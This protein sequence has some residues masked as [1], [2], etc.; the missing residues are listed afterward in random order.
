MSHFFVPSLDD[1]EIFQI[2]FHMEGPDKDSS[3]M[4]TNEL[5]SLIETVFS[6]ENESQDGSFW[7]TQK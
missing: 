1:I 7:V 6:L 4:G 3:D 2:H 5:Y